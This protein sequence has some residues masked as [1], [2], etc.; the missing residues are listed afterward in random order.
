MLSNQ[1]EHIFHYEKRFHCHR[2][3]HL[4]FVYE[5]STHDQITQHPFVS[6]EE[7]P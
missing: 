3:W 4:Y 2:P 5:R 6:M 7:S 1:S